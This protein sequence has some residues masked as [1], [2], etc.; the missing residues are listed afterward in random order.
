V[1]TMARGKS[2]SFNP[3][4]PWITGAASVKPRPPNSI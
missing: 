1:P 2:F 4:N 3:I